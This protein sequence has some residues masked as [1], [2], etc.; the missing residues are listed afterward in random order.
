MPDPERPQPVAESRPHPAPLRTSDLDSPLATRSGE[1]A[2]VR[3][4]LY[5]PRILQQQLADDPESRWWTAEGTA[6]LVDISGFTKLSER[7]SRKGREGAEQITDAISGCFEAILLVAYDHGGSLLKFG[8]DALLLWFSGDGHA[9]RAC[10]ASVLMRRALRRVG[11][12]KLPGA[13]VTLRM[14]QGVHSG[15][16]HFFAVGGSHVELLPVG[17][18]W[19]CLV[20]TEH[21]AGASEI[22][23]SV[24]TA[25]LLPPRCTGDVPGPARILLRDPGTPAQKVPLA[26]RPKLPPET[27]ARGLSTAVRQH[28][29]AG[30]G[31]SEHRPVTIAFIRFEGTDALIAREGADAAAGALQQLVGVV[32]AA[33][34]QADVSFLASDVDADGGKLILTAG[35]PRVTG[36]DEERMLLAL[37]RIVE[38]DLAL[39]I[40]IGVNR[41][42]VFAGDIGPA[43]RRTY[44]V[45]G[46]AVNLA[47]RVMAKAQA[48]L[49]YAT[50]DVLEHSNT[51]FTTQA[52][53][54]FQVKGKA[55]PIHAWSVGPAAGSRARHGVLKQL[56][57]IGRDGELATLRQAV[58]QARDGAGALIEIVGEAGVG[59]TRLLEAMRDDAKGLRQLHAVCEAYTAHTPYSLWRE[60]LREFM[61]FGRD[62]PE[63]VIAEHLRESVRSAAPE[64]LPWLPLIAIAF[65]VDVEPT[66]EVAMLAER[67]RRARL[68]DAV[69]GFLAA[70]LRGPAL[71][72]IEGAHHMDAASAELLVAVAGDLSARP[73]VFGVARRPGDTGFVAPEAITATRIELAPLALADARRLARAVADDH[74][75]P[76]HVLD[77][78]AQRSGGNPQFLRDLLRAAIES[79][80]VGGLPDSAEAA[81][82][83]RIDALAPQDR[84]LVRRAAVFGMTF[85]PRM[86]SWLADDADSAP[87]S[88]AAF[89]RLQELFDE[90]GDGYL[91]FRRSLLRD[92]AYEGLPYRVRRQLHRSVAARLEEEAE[93]PEEMAG[94][95]SLHY[96]V[97]GAY[98]DAW[99]CA[100]AA[101]KRAHG[102]YAYVEAAGLYA[103]ALDAGRRLAEVSEK[104]LAG[105]HEALGDSLNLAGEFDKAS[106]AYTDA[107]RLTG[108]EPLAQAALLLKRSRLE[109]KLGKYPQALRWAARARRAVGDLASRDAAREAAQSSSWYA[110]LLQAEGRSADAVRWA[111]RAVAEAEAADDP[112]ALGSAYFT[113]GWAY[114]D[115]GRDDW[116]PPVMRALEASRRSGDRVKQ[117]AILQNVGTLCMSHGRWDEAMTYYEQGREQCVKIGDTVGAALASMNIAEILADRGDPDEAE[118]MLKETLPIWKASK[119]RY[120]LGACNWLLGRAMLRAG[121][122]EDALRRLE[123]AKTCFAHVGADQDMLGV[124]ARIAECRLV[125]RDVDAALTVADEMLARARNG[126]GV[127]TVVPLL[128][129]VRGCAL[130]RK[131]DT[132]GARKALQ[133]SLDAARTRRDLFELMQTLATLIELDRLEGIE[134]DGGMVEESRAL[135][136]RLNL[137]SAPAVLLRA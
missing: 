94:I 79:G 128:E 114:V 102:T 33:A 89:E 20:T 8:G 136:A 105:V 78:V 6:A 97:A 55:Q 74:P 37:R 93:D 101:G 69:G 100:T 103:R 129:R 86:L 126:H 32:Q 90:E 134:P 54:P 107:R 63:A 50:A 29:L 131:G 56:P 132:G 83:A 122:V 117:A 16:F 96:H 15:Q 127:A 51:L 24:E 125:A 111:Q 31:S 18:A 76:M 46:D 2:A 53:E 99:R 42:A 62:D 10:R 35:A 68:H 115:L 87:P 52:L 14:S 61:G 66:P 17:P 58:A 130:F 36:D 7:L 135:Y 4:S 34:E 13:R 28:V 104:E 77:T 21:E 108:D 49:I 27:L 64:L 11:T 84:A 3:A 91:R 48:G 119:Y 113:M 123:E 9:T 124:D 23:V 1:D 82:M 116:E 80:G 95:L 60:L 57:L 72:E 59:K 71:I 112:D 22:Y 73:W 70:T 44:T 88:P 26:A 67:N 106:A 81:A 5:V 133:A 98:N 121:R 19:S 41:G 47:A 39:P 12:I 120:L 25:A 43:Y 109:E 30:G 118:A 137:R 85:H 110:T 45:M 38:A 65:D 92:A 40:R 75:L